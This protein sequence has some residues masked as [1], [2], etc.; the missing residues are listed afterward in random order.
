[1]P[2]YFPVK[3]DRISACIKILKSLDLKF[4]T[5]YVGGGNMWMF[6]QGVLDNVAEC[7]LPEK[8]THKRFV[9]DMESYALAHVSFLTSKPFIGCYVVASNDYI[10][11]FYNQL[12][13][14]EQ[15]SR[16]VPYVLDLASYLVSGI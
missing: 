6:D 9:S 5:A 11:E 1:M 13:V 15:M 10:D 14:S 16:I 7:M 2:Y 3:K 8:K 4:Q 12:L